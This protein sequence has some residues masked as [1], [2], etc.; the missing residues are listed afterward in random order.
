VTA[1]NSS[2]HLPLPAGA[3]SASAWQLDMRGQP[4]RVLFGANRTDTDHILEVST[5]A[6]QL[7]DGSIDDG[8]Q[9]EPPKSGSIWPM[10]I[11]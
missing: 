1:S 4:Y 3:A 9:V 11:R 5:T 2:P 7:A 6:I 8:S 10:T